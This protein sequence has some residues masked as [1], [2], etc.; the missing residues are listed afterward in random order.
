LPASQSMKVLVFNCGSSSLKFEMLE[1][2]RDGRKRKQIARGKFEEIGPRAKAIM[3]DAS[4]KKTETLVPVENH[5]AAAMRAL[6]WLGSTVDDSKPEVVVHRVVH[7]GEQVTAPAIANEGVMLAL[8]EASRFA[9]LHNPPALATLRAVSEKLAGVPA[10]VVPDTAFHHTLPEHARAYA[11]PRAL[12]A[13]H[14]IRRFGFHGIGHAWMMERYAEI[15]GTPVQDLRLV[16]LQLGAGCSATAIRGGRSV[17]TS[18]GLTPLE[19]L[20]MATRSGDLDP[21]IFG[22]LAKAEQITPE[23]IEEILNRDSGLLGVSGRSDD[24]RELEAH[25]VGDE[26]S[27]LA[28]KMFCYRVRK[29]IGAYLAALG[30]ADAIIFGGGIGE[31][32]DSTRAHVCAGLEQLGIVLDETRNREA[33]GREARINA[34]RSS[35]SAHV[36]PLDEELYMARAAVRLVHNI[37]ST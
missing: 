27:A 20:M 23:K 18:M 19:G 1:L 36:I 2:A 32:S 8:N 7:G 31:N 30:G 28:L 3:T 4:G 37:K 26:N 29:Y 6:Q 24:L 12:A 11:I 5:A 14:G 16:T 17:D 25:R 22:Y 9:P 10:V 15:C 34:D 21:A 13:R 35:I 33:N